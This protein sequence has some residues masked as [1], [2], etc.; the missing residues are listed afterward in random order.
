MS[1]LFVGFLLDKE[2]TSLIH[3]DQ[4][5]FTHNQ[6]SANIIRHSINSMWASRSFSSSISTRYLDQF[7]FDSTLLG[8]LTHILLI[9]RL[10]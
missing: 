1:R 2:M 10:V 3:E 7:R 8:L 6:C 5:E 4:V 9:M